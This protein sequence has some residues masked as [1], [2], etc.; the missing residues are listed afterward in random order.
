MALS[1]FLVYRTYA[2]LEEQAAEFAEFAAKDFE[3][4]KS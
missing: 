3:L 4:R 1:P 2:K